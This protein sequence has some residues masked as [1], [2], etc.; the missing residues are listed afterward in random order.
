MKKF[1]CVIL[2]Y[3]DRSAVYSQYAIDFPDKL[4]V[5]GVID[6]VEHKLKTAKKLFNLKNEQ[7][8]KCLDDFLDKDI[9]CDFVINGT[10]DNLH[11]ETSMKLLNR[12]YNMLLEK[13]I[14]SNVKE[15]LEIQELAN[16]NNCKIV[17][18]HVLRYTPFYLKIKE[19]ISEGAIGKVSSIQMNEHVWHGHFINAFVRGKWRSEKECGSGLLLQKC[20][21][22]TDLLCWLNSE[23]EPALI[24]SFGSRSLF[25]PENAPQGSTEYC[26]N[27]PKKEECLFNAYDLELKKDFCP[28]YTWQ[29]MNKPIDEITEEE[30]IEF[31]KT[32]VYGKCVYKTDMDIVD[33]QC[34]SIQYKN[35][36]IATLN[37][38]G[39]AT[40][41]GRCIH[42][43][44]SLGE[45]VGSIEENTITLRKY[46][47]CEKES[48]LKENEI[49]IDLNKVNALQEENQSMKGHY[50]GDA[51][52]MQDLMN[53]LDSGKETLSTTNINDSVKGH[54]ICY[55]AEISRK[56]NRIVNIDKEF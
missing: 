13:P 50:G 21:H 31:L 33:R 35:G 39:G 20:C 12:K 4:E 3:G 9:K 32:N 24:S 28:Q 44:G 46:F 47:S 25:T 37:M 43:V 51:L 17:V 15:L 27:C 54:L 7:L 49:V 38:V 45:I 16:K 11:Y 1:T 23:T 55:A 42:V 36:S 30:K 6:P 34:V 48:M 2:G 29:D 22:D 56:E 10:M 19:L 53:L 40:I 14:T 5:V 41:A 26:Y 18:C 8:F 52:I